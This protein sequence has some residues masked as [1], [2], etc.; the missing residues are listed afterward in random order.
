[1]EHHYNAVLYRP[2]LQIVLYKKTCLFD[3][4]SSW[5]DFFFSENEICDP[6]VIIPTN[7]QAYH[8]HIICLFSHLHIV[9]GISSADYGMLLLCATHNGSPLAVHVPLMFLQSYVD[10]LTVSM[11]LLFWGYE[12]LL[13]LDILIIGWRVANL[14]GQ[15]SMSLFIC[16]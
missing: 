11:P 13:T 14:F 12:P 15:S 6:K 4:T 2:G 8:N 3:V 7:P 9:T 10:S 1:M 16:L 5:F